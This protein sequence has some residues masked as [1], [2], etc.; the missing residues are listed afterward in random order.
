MRKNKEE[1]EDVRR[2][3]MEFSIS[4]YLG[5]TDEEI[6]QMLEKNS[7]KKPNLEEQIVKY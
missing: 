2:C 7:L 6:T 5:F 4:E 3:K 1:K